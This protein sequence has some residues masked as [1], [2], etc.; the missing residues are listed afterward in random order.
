MTSDEL[1]REVEM[2]RAVLSM[3]L[4]TLIANVRNPRAMVEAMNAHFNALVD[5]SDGPQSEK[6]AIRRRAASFFSEIKSAMP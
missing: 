5:K 3:T 1:H 2:L 6:D 4:T